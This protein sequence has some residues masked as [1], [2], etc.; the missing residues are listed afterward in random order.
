MAQQLGFN[1]KI[2]I[3]PEEVRGTAPTDFGEKNDST[4]HYDKF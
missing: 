4:Q 2:I 3:F 1:S